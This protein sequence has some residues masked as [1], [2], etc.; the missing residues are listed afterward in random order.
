M[1]APRPWPSN[2]CSA[3]PCDCARLLPANG[4]YE[5][6][7][8]ARKRPYWMTNAD[9]LLYFAALWEVYPVGGHEYLSV[10]LITQAAASQRAR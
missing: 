7:G 1:P 3:E 10:A 8:A 5:W 4:F 6:R 9:S 2:R